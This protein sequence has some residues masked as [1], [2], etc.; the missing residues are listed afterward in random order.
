MVTFNIL[1][2]YATRVGLNNNH[3]VASASATLALHPLPAAMAAVA[4]VAIAATMAAV[5][6]AAQL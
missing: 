2:S 6:L 5:A 3:M 4:M 1:G